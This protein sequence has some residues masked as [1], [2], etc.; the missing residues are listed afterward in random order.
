MIKRNLELTGLVVAIVGGLC[1][2]GGMVE[3]FLILPYEMRSME[4]RVEAMEVLSKS[5]HDVIV[6]IDERV[7]DILRILAHKS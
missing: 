7:N 2:I 5:D 3:A 6:R 4:K 1:G